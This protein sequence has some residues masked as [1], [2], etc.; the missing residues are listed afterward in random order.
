MTR[1]F[2][3]SLFLFFSFIPSIA[4]AACSNPA[5]EAGEQIYNADYKTMQFC[6]GT[7]WIS[8]KGGAVGGNLPQGT[9]CGW[10]VGSGF[11]TDCPGTGASYTNM[12]TCQGINLAS[13]TSC[14]SGYTFAEGLT[15]VVPSGGFT[16]P[17][18]FCS[19]ICI[20]N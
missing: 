18:V 12:G 9:H 15:S 7:N 8:M 14:P 2:L 19:R 10:A 20:K 1:F 3:L 13:S 17:K 6:D 5:G 16:Q 11:G 4:Q